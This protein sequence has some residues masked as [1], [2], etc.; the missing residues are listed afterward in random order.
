MTVSSFIRSAGRW[1]GMGA[2]ALI[3]C[4]CCNPKPP[5]PEEEDPIVQVKV[6]GAYG[7]P[8]G[9][10]VYND[11]RNQLSVLLCADGTLSFRI[12]DEGERK[13]ISISGLPANLQQGAYVQVHYRVMVNGYTLRSEVFEKV[14]VVKNN[15]S[16]AWLKK[17]NGVYFV[18]KI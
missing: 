7:L 1:T 6:P 17:D 8:D 18:I 3:L 2:L 11:D 13:V 10:Q 5:E 12:L 14:H 4:L 9:N 15:G 16:M